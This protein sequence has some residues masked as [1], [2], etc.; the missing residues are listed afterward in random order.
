MTTTTTT[1]TTT[2]SNVEF[3]GMVLTK[4]AQ[5]GLLGRAN[6]AAKAALP[7]RAYEFWHT[8][9]PSGKLAEY[10]KKLANEW[11]VREAI[12]AYEEAR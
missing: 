2:A 11:P 10:R 1:A 4:W 9:C 5:T 8:A 6:E 7:V 3:L 12:R